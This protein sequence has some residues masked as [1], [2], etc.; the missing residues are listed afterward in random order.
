MSFR[1]GRKLGKPF[2]VTKEE[3][4][5][6]HVLSAEETAEFL[7]Q[8]KP[9]EPEKREGLTMEQAE[10]IMGTDFLGPEAVEKTF[11][12]KLNEE[13]IPE[14]PFS[15][16]DL[17]RAKE[18]GQMLV[19]RV[20]K[21]ADDEPMSLEAMN[22][23]LVKKW[24]KEG[25]GNLLNTSD[26]WKKWLGQDL[27]TKET[28]RKGWSLVSKDLLPES[29]NKNYLEQTEIIIATLKNEVFKDKEMPKEYI[30]AIADF[31]SK[32]VGLTKLIDKDWKK[33][34][35]ELSGLDITKLTRQTFS[36][37]IYDLAIYHSINN[38]RLLPNKYTSS[39]SLDPDGGVVDLGGFDAGGVYGDGWF[40]GRRCGGLGVSFSRSL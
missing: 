19:L 28:P 8:E 20:E 32:K 25:K 23:I 10:T 7:E 15:E 26:N 1:E 6:F 29:T 27:F 21:T 30:E 37:V 9:R 36:E 4:A 12:I 14:I 17:E 40:P 33:A 3:L 38:K 18:L 5:E 24:Q 34:A 39:A 13:Q 2:V 22:A 35:K 11:G 31:E 16:A